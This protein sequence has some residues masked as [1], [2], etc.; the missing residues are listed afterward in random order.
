MRLI[1]VTLVALLAPAA[2]HAAWQPGGNRI[3]V[4]ELLDATESG[5]QLVV[6]WT[7][8]AAPDRY[9]VRAH[10]WTS[11]GDIAAGWPSEGV[12]VSDLSGYVATPVVCED[13]AGG[14]FVAW[15]HVQGAEK[16]FL[17]QHLSASGGVAPGWAPEGLQLATTGHYTSAPVMAHDGAGG[18]LV[19]WS[20]ATYDGE[21][22]VSV[23]IHRIDAGGV[24]NAGWP[25]GGHTIPNAYEVGLVV[26]DQQRVFVSTAAYDPA[27]RRI[28]G[29]RVQRLAADATPDPG[30]P[31]DGALVPNENSPGQLGLF[32]DGV[33]GVFAGWR[34]VV[35]C[36]DLCPPSFGSTT[37][38]LASG[39]Q[40]ES[41]MPALT[42]YSSA[43]D[44]TGGM[45]LGTVTKG[46]PGVV[47]LDVAGEPMPGWA[48]EGNAAMTEVV[49]PYDVLVA[50]DGEGGAFVA[51]SDRRTGTNRLYAS[52]LDAA[53][54]LA[55]GWPATGSVVDANR[56]GSP[57]EVRLVSLDEGVVV[58]I[59]SEGSTD[60]A[61]AYVT[62][63]RPGEPGPIAELGPVPV[64][65]GFG[66]RILANPAR[67]PIVATV[68]LPS[69]GP[70]RAD[71]IDAAGRVLES[72]D[73]DF[74]IQAQGAVR[75]NQARQLRPGVYWVRVT[76]GSRQANRKV[77]VIE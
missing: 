56:G 28:L 72:R 18:V 59:W 36:L 76:Q 5:G 33:G 47:R 24:P 46:R 31:E 71:L 54:R 20:E 70:A 60:G 49:S 22:R 39:T 51:W 63:L 16:D 38:I 13:G 7:R 26:D 75:F 14:V 40:D 55:D 61:V 3:G 57:Y 45:L 35:I 4:V 43:V 11:D 77:I 25:A 62:V 19:G 8:Q 10:A 41:W 74:A 1:L 58:A 12:L 37:R 52:R 17:L 53:G 68:E 2:A 27:E 50:G 9:E 6:A 65:V 42:G 30:W 23:T 64:D 69:A 66:I 48:P 32:P 21:T 67:G 73:F 15:T 34:N 44:G 29:M